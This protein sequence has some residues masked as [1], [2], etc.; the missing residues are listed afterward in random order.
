VYRWAYSVLWTLPVRVCVVQVDV[1]VVCL[2]RLSDRTIFG[3]FSDDRD[4]T[5]CF[6]VIRLGEG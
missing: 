1:R 3:S 6:S 4:R 2:S 5:V